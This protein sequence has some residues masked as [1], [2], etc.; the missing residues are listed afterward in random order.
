MPQ[1][2]GLSKA[3]EMLL[4]G[5]KID[6]TTALSWN[7]VSQIINVPN[8]EEE[9]QHRQNDDN[10]AGII[11]HVAQQICEQLDQQ[12]LSLPLGSTTAQ[13]FVSLLRGGS[14]QQR[15]DAL[16]HTCQEE[17]RQLDLRFRK[18]HVLQ[19]ASQLSFATRGG[20]AAKAKATISS[21]L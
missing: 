20:G 13:I 18:G 5:K 9:A 21:K 15:R 11:P 4:L 12:L 1:T 10:N 3:N 14:H 19:A 16:I 2:M 6:A 8:K 7:I 17:L